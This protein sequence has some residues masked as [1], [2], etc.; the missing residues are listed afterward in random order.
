MEV[1][2]VLS[3]YLPSCA[4]HSLINMRREVSSSHDRV[5]VDWRP[6]SV[7]PPLQ[8]LPVSCKVKPQALGKII[9]GPSGAGPQWTDPPASSLT[10][11]WLVLTSQGMRDSVAAARCPVLPACAVPSPW[12]AFSN[13]PLAGPAQVPPPLE[14]PLTLKILRVLLCIPCLR[15][16][17]S[18]HSTPN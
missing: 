3:Q 10:S 18:A 16:S 15:A 5:S 7:P 12:Y 1:H 11:P 2:S 14:S 6:F 4:F 13:S 9:Q 17:L 8:Y